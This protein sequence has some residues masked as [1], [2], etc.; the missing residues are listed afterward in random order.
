M[1]LPEIRSDVKINTHL[2]C[3][4]ANK[5]IPTIL[6]DFYLRIYYTEHLEISLAVERAT[7]IV[8]ILVE[9]K[10]NLKMYVE[11][12]KYLLKVYTWQSSAKYFFY[13]LICTFIICP[14]GHTINFSSSPKYFFYYLICTLQFI[15]LKIL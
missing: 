6:K 3:T 13:Y 2:I 10:T 4:I 5:N 15:Q 14:A 8:V 1:L 7:T 9:F 11:V 12:T